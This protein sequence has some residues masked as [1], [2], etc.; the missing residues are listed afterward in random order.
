MP[1]ATTTPAELGGDCSACAPP[2][3]I[4]SPDAGK[5]LVVN[6]SNEGATV[7]NLR[8]GYTRTQYATYKPTDQVAS[9]FKLLPAMI[10]L[11]P[12]HLFAY[13]T[14]YGQA[15]ILS[16]DKVDRIDNTFGLPAMGK[17]SRAVLRGDGTVVVAAE[18]GT[19]LV[20]PKSGETRVVG[21]AVDVLT[22]DGTLA[23]KIDPPQN[24]ADSAAFTTIKVLDIKSAKTVRDA[25]I[26]G[27]LAKFAEHTDG[28]LT[29]LR[30]KRTGVSTTGT[31]LLSLDLAT[32]RVRSLGD[33]ASPGVGAIASSADELYVEESGA[34]AS[35]S[36]RDAAR[37]AL[38]PVNTAPRRA[39]GM[40]L[41]ADGRTLVVESEPEQMLF[42]VPVTPDEWTVMACRIAGQL[43]IRI[44]PRW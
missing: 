40:G 26:P 38:I 22:T 44:W 10:W 29:L 15:W 36:L 4:V 16:G 28:G 33:L 6:N 23:V 11:D 43:G 25:E 8:N 19:I 24:T 2:R 12:E 14:Q 13:S 35:Y 31:E 41:T 39:N 1:L 9:V 3:V 27:S 5:A 32:G 17:H 7:V 30:D 37:L 21:H 18:D 34:I 42:K 20:N